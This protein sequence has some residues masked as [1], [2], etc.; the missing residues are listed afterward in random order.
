M[1]NRIFL[2]ALVCVLIPTLLIACSAIGGGNAG[3]GKTPIPT[4][5]PATLPA[6]SFESQKNSFG[7]GQC[8][9][10]AVNLIAAWVAAGK[11]EK[12]SFPFKDT[13]GKECT[14][15]FPADVQPLFDQPNVW[16]TGAIACTTCHGAD[17]KVSA[18]QMNLTTYADI[19][20]GSRR[21]DGAAKGNDILGASG[22]WDKAK[23]YVVLSTRFMPMGVPSTNHPA[24][25]L[26]R[27]GTMK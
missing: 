20:A 26:V 22:S 12:D 7:M 8:Q 1:K 23:L 21:A 14:A 19:L 5:I 17:L 11:P 15:S 9:V 27:V 16:Y 18:A 13:N 6:V 25:P 24:G 2:T 10:R 4:L 3:V